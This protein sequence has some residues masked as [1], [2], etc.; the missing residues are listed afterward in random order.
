MPVSTITPQQLHQAQQGATP[1][2]VI[3]VR[4]ESEFAELPKLPEALHI[5]MK[6]VPAQL[7]K[8]PKSV[9]VVC[10]SGKRSAQVAE[11][12]KTQGKEAWSLAEGMQG[13][14]SL[15]GTK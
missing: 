11:W 2:A 3:D 4:E 13:W 10:R 5:P 14:V 9:V 7:A 15:Y 1:Y 12:L 6:D 8:I